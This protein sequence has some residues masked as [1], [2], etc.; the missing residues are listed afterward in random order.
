MMRIPLPIRAARPLAGAVLWLVA[1][2]APAFAQETAIIPTRVIYPGET[3][4]AGLLE[5]VTLRRGKNNLGAV[6]MS[7]AEL[8][9][10]VARRTLLPGRLIPAGSV[11][12]PYL[13]EAGAPVQ[14]LF[15]Q[16]ALTISLSAVPL[17]PGAVGDLIKV[18]N[19]DSGAVFSGIVMADGTIRVGAT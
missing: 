17:E 6:A 13:V 15:V 10:K 12:E 7:A 19:V 16:G 8:E 1:A 3:I 18:R 9:G 5:A 11:R 4:S 2:M 14:V